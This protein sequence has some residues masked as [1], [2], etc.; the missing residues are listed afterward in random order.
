MKRPR[1]AGS[2]PRI[3]SSIIDCSQLF[4]CNALFTASYHKLANF[5]WIM[6]SREIETMRVRVTG[7]G[8]CLTTAA[9]LISTHSDTEINRYKPNKYKSF[10]VMD[11]LFYY[12]HFASTYNGLVYHL[13]RS[14]VPTNLIWA[15]LVLYWYR[16]SKVPF[17]R[18]VQVYHVGHIRNKIVIPGTLSSCRCDLR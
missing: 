5:A 3:V 4:G 2:A 11:L 7:S 1:P 16:T 18:S 8:G 13:K 17:D 6:H 12:L 15:C 10:L 14:S 9:A